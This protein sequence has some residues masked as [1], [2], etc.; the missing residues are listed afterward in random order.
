MSQS[1]LIRLSCILPWPNLRQT[2]G[3]LISICFSLKTISEK[4]PHFLVLI[5]ALLLSG[6]LFAPASGD[7]FALPLELYVNVYAAI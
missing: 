5:P 1:L 7:I 6:S 4:K 2:L 3:L